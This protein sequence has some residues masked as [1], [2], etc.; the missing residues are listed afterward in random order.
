MFYIYHGSFSF[1][2]L[3]KTTTENNKYRISIYQQSM[4]KKIIVYRKTVCYSLGMDFKMNIY[5]FENN[6]E[7]ITK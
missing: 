1:N 4:F 7:P 2:Y 5:S 3:Q 6:T